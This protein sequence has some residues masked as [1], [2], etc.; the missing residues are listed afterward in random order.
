MVTDHS[1]LAWKIPRTEGIGRLQS[2]GS[3]TWLSIHNTVYIHV[4]TNIQYSI[5]TNIYIYKYIY[6]HTHTHIYIYIYTVYSIYYPRKL[7]KLITWT[8][9]LSNSMKLWAMPCRATQD[10]WVIVE[11]SD[12]TWSTGEGN[13]KPLQYFYLENPMNSIKQQKDITMKD[14]LSSR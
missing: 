4:Y 2:M 8:T 6:T 14:Q 1:I 11:S 13:G 7:T 3:W 12:T 9:A 10:G 5:H